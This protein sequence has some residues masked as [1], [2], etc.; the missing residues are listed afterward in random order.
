M[1]I[2]TDIHKTYTIKYTN[3]EILSEKGLNRVQ[4]NDKNVLQDALECFVTQS[5]KYILIC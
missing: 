1:T 4:D 2:K 3:L 5:N